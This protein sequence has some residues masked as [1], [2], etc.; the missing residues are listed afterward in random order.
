MKK[1]WIQPQEGKH[2]P[3]ALVG[4]VITYT[5]GHTRRAIVD[6]AD[7]PGRSWQSDLTHIDDTPRYRADV[8]CH[9][10]TEEKGK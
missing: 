4:A 9:E 6:P 7:W 2:M 8:Q 1:M 5:C 10:C 3:S